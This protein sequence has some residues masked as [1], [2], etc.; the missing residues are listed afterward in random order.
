LEGVKAC[1]LE[2]WKQP[3]IVSV[4]Y[5]NR[6][7]MGGNQSEQIAWKSLALQEVKRRGR[8]NFVLG[9][10]KTE[11][12]RSKSNNVTVLGRSMS[13]MEEKTKTSAARG[14]SRGIQKNSREVPDFE[15]LPGR[16]DTVKTAPSRHDRETHPW[17]GINGGRH[18]KSSR[19]DNNQ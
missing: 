11:R 18:W 6:G 12:A 13:R 5:P 7:K 4:A 16:I 3:C 17:R 19:V 1:K 10:K 9:T 2:I 15:K 14:R 8:Q